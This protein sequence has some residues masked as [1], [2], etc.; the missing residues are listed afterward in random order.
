MSSFLQEYGSY[1]RTPVPF[2]IWGILTLITGL[3]GPYGSYDAL[4]FHSRL[5]FWGVVLGLAILLGSAIRV[6]VHAVIGLRDFQR[7]AFVVALLV[8]LLL[9]PPLYFLAQGMIGQK[10]PHTPQI[11][12]VAF[13]TFSTSLGVGAFRHS[14]GIVPLAQD[15]LAELPPLSVEEAAIPLP[16]I[17]Q[18]L[19]PALQG[20]LLSMAVRDHYVDVVTEN[21][22]ASLLMRF[23]DAMAEAEG[24]EGAQVH[25]SHWVAWS[26]VRQVEKAAGKVFLVLSN[27][28]RIPVSRNHRAKLEERGLL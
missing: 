2:L 28:S 11:A 13:L 22:Q 1:F 9:T 8:S 5:V 15:P 25:R 4:P 23:S 26:A 12:E 24:I 18:R 20:P 21:G 27:D 10:L 7:G 3:T 16:R 6:F 14:L 17:V 19:D